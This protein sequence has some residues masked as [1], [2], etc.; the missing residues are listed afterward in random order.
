[1]FVLAVASI[2]SILITIISFIDNANCYSIDE[3][4]DADRLSLTNLKLVSDVRVFPSIKFTCHGII[5]NWII[6]TTANS[7]PVIMIRH[8][9][10]TT[11]NAV[12][13]NTE[14][15]SPI[16]SN[17]NVYN[18]TVTNEVRVQPGDILM[19]N[20]TGTEMYYQQYNGPFNYILGPAL[21][22]MESNDYPLI[23]AIISK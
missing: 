6:G 18:I 1:M 22:R 15:I 4:F 11:T 21:T 3:S 16:D 7:H 9:D 8:S 20:S 14:T 12:S 2:S 13:I 17:V 5:T 23:S 19:I 10:N